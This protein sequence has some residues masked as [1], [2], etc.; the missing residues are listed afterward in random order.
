MCFSLDNVRQ[1]QRASGFAFTAAHAFGLV[2]F[3]PDNPVLP[4]FS[5]PGTAAH[6]EVFYG[7]AE[8]AE[9]MTLI[10]CDNN[11]GVGFRNHA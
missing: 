10:V 9:F 3:Q 11:H 2:N 6:A 4:K 1:M 8:T 7:A 5:R